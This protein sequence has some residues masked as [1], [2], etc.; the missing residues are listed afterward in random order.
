M[1]TYDNMWTLVTNNK[2]IHTEKTQHV[3]FVC[4]FQ[5]QL[6]T[7]EKNGPCVEKTFYVMTFLMY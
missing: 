7:S 5:W 1:N 3:G 4:T 6:Q 2:R